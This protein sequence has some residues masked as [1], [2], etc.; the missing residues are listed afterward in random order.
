[1]VGIVLKCLC[2]FGFIIHSELIA[3]Q[4]SHCLGSSKPAFKEGE[5]LVETESPSDKKNSSKILLV[6]KDAAL[7]TEKVCIYLEIPSLF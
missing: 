2:L 1:M 3:I 4:Q 6:N 5:K 7:P